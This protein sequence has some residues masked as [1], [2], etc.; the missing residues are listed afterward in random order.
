ME[1]IL[2]KNKKGVSLVELIAYI[3]LYGVVMSLLATLVF[4]IVKAARKV[5]SQSIIN[6]GATLMYTEIL[7]GTIGLNPDTVSEVT[8]SG[9][10][11]SVTFEKRFYYN[12]EG[13]RKSIT[14]ND[15]YLNKITKITYSYTKG[16]D[17]I[18]VKRVLGNGTEATSTINLDFNM[19]ITSHD[20]NDI[21]NVF[22][23]DTQ[24][25][26]NKYVTFHG[27]LHYDDRKMEFNFIVPVFTAKEESGD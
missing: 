16:N 14:E 15:T 12:D 5:D 19:T 4:V 7:G 17:N 22:T 27:D 2:K 21:S 24:N 1:H 18:D 13:E 3:A 26:S 6:R 11:I 8:T 9:N 20:S 23:V 10:T 25:A